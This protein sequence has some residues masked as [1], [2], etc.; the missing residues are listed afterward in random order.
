MQPSI[1]ASTCISR[2]LAKVGPKSSTKALRGGALTPID[3]VDL[4]RGQIKEK[5]GSRNQKKHAGILMFMLC[6]V[7]CCCKWA[8]SCI[9]LFEDEL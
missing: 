6:S 3:C 5:P 9:Y 4:C 7:F 8:L 2:H 1:P